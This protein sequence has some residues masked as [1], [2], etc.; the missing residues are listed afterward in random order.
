M[1]Q[2]LEFML[3]LG[4]C[5]CCSC[6]GASPLLHPAQVLTQ[7]N[8]RFGA[9]TAGHFATGSLASAIDNAILSSS[10]SPSQR[11]DATYAR[12]SLVAASITPGVS[13]FV[14][15]RAG[16]GYN[17]E[18]GLAYTGRTIRFDARY[19]IQLDDGYALSMGAGASA[20]YSYESTFKTSEVPGL[21]L[22]SLTGWGL[23]VPIL[24]GWQSTSDLVWWWLGA[25]A[26]YERLGGNVSLMNPSSPAALDP[27]PVISGINARR[28]YAS[29]LGGL[30][31]GFRHLH[32]AVE[33]QSGY[34]QA[35][36]TLW[37]KTVD[38][39]GVT[40]TP[41]AALLGSF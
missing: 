4:L 22:E 15:A 6:A 34:H 20:L 2:A 33:F 11:P 21:N 12:G 28:Y 13:P 8:V 16:L 30:A 26:G 31:F 18:A 7:G 24:F 40:L 5:A 17:S 32:A 39:S 38:V 36:G 14:A 41:S 9:G 23:D 27:A 1:R 35:S 10:S 25:R 3:R 19:A 37:D 29:G